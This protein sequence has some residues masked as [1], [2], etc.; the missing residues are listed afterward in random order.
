MITNRQCAEFLL[1]MD[2]NLG[3]T[4]LAH[5]S[6]GMSHAIVADFVQSELLTD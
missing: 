2:D 3:S 6:K 1:D 5:R 4:H